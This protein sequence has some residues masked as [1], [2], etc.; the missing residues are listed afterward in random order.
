MDGTG[1]I[2]LLRAACCRVASIVDD[3]QV[4]PHR[5]RSPFFAQMNV[6]GR[7]QPLHFS[8]V[9]RPQPYAGAT[10]SPTCPP[11]T[12]RRRRAASQRGALPDG[13]VGRCIDGGRPFDGGRRRIRAARRQSR[14]GRLPR[15]VAFQ[16]FVSG[17]AW[18]SNREALDAEKLSPVQMW[19]AGVVPCRHNP[20]S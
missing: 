7:F 10:C 15:R 18:L 5:C 3:C 12:R 16:G 1:G 19:S 17:T 11:R 8:R 6:L 13:N 14:A 9:G 20:F 4:W 2:R